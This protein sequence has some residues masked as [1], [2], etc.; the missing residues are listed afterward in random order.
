MEKQYFCQEKF[1]DNAEN[2][3]LGIKSWNLTSE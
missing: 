2:K 3:M 1:N